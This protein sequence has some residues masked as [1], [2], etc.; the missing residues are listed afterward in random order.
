MNLQ[1][2]KNAVTSKVGR[3]ILIAQKNSP[4]IMFAAGVTGVIGATVLACRAT[5]KLEEVLAKSDNQLEQVR[6]LNH[7]DYS[8]RDRKHDE[9]KI[10]MRT[11]GRVIKL[12]GPSLAVGV[13]S[14][15]ALT[16]SHVTLTRR[17]AAV[18]AAYSAL[19]RGFNE[20]RERVRE[21]YG[22]EKDL[23]FRHGAE[24]RTEVVVDEH[25]DDKTLTHTIAPSDIPSI[26]ARFFDETST[27]WNRQ[28]EYNQ[29]FLN[30]Q[31]RYANDLL[32]SRGHLFLNEVYDMLGMERS[33]AGAVVGWVAGKNGK[34]NFVDFGIYEDRERARAF[35]NANERSI[36][37][38]F[39]VDG[40]IYDLLDD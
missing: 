3:Q 24:E 27:S 23:Q 35:V 10:T 13:V 6:S 25:G 1:N 8:E 9:I 2:V 21:E 39:N 34:D 22:D 40:I 16:G 31:Q 38:D 4:T 26:Y 20:Y 5:L 19:D 37:L 33:K 17:N 28:P 14:V 30:V 36:L 7:A 32:K 12:Y 11:A 15:A 29:V 18:M